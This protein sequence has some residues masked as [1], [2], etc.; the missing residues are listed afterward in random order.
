M[1]RIHSA[2]ICIYNV[3]YI[4]SLSHP[5]T[6]TNIHIH[7]GTFYNFRVQSSLKGGIGVRNPNGIIADPIQY[8]LN[9]RWLIKAQR[10]CTSLFDPH[11]VVSITVVAFSGFIQKSAVATVEMIFYQ[12]FQLYCTMARTIC[13]SCFSKNLLNDNTL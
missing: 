8:S 6:H 1:K 13:H 11:L 10:P 9:H 5:H 3:P 7:V 4:L 2:D 12:H